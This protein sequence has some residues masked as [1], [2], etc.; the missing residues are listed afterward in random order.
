MIFLKN[1]HYIVF[2][3]EILVIWK[4]VIELSNT[5]YTEGK[6]IISRA[7]AGIATDGG[8]QPRHMPAVSLSALTRLATGGSTRNRGLGAPSEAQ[9][10]PIP[11]RERH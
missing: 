10:V 1:Y 9:L 7:F 4:T 6:G 5:A 3:I 2:L 11:G 8:Y